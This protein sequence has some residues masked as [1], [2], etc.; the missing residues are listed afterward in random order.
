MDFGKKLDGLI[1]PLDRLSSSEL[2]PL[3]WGSSSSLR[4]IKTGFFAGRGATAAYGALNEVP[5]GA[6][7]DANIPAFGAVDTLFV[8]EVDCGRKGEEAGI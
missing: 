4:S 5:A 7:T 3:Y 2:P 1:S 8:L 6:M